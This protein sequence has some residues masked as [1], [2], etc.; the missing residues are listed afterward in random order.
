MITQNS[1]YHTLKSKAKFPP[2][3]TAYCRVV[4][5]LLDMNVVACYKK[6][7]VINWYYLQLIPIRN[8]TYIF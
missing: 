7:L 4:C 5:Y 1:K 2:R 8:A 6:D 3:Y